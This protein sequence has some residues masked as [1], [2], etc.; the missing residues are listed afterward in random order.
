MSVYNYHSRVAPVMCL[1]LRTRK[2]A[3]WSQLSGLVTTKASTSLIPLMS[4]PAQAEVQS[5]MQ[6]PPVGTQESQLFSAS[7]ACCLF[8]R[9]NLI[10]GSWVV[11]LPRYLS[12][13]PY[14]L[15]LGT[16]N[17]EMPSAGRKG[18]R[19]GYGRPCEKA[20]GCVRLAST[21]NE[22]GKERALGGEWRVSF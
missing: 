20:S 21:Q 14:P 9:A 3:S 22:R 6:P 13:K 10:C 11:L 7:S 5:G 19:A 18:N 17:H 4:A 15:G 16:E 8:L 2:P 1:S 12:P